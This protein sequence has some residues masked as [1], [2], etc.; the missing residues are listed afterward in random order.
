MKRKG[1]RSH[2]TMTGIKGQNKRHAG[3]DSK[4]FEN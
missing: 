1:A 4:P 3:K 2:E